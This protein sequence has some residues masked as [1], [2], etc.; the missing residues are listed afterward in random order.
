VFDGY[1]VAD[2]AIAEDAAERFASLAAGRKHLA[3]PADPAAVAQLATTYTNAA[4][5]TITVTRKYGRTWFQIGALESEMASKTNRDGSISF[6]P[7]VPG[8]SWFEVFVNGD[9]LLVGDA[10]HVY[11][12]TPVE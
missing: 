4:L 11:V 12:F 2:Q 7:L 6:V 5:G 3:I 8:F 10:Q 1:P 9:N